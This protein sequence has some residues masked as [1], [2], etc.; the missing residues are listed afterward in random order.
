M[1]KQ[2]LKLLEE[3]TKRRHL[4][5]QQTTQT[6]GKYESIFY[7]PVYM[8]VHISDKGLLPRMYTECASE[9]KP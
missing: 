8:Y 7:I 9:R 2:N 3:N 6:G 1:G 4:K 5:N